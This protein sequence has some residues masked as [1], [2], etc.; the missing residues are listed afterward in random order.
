[1]YDIVDGSDGKTYILRQ[2]KYGWIDVI[3]HDFMNV[4]SDNPARS[5][6]ANKDEENYKEWLALIDQAHKV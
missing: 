4:P 2:I 3:T 5:L 6:Q 1:M